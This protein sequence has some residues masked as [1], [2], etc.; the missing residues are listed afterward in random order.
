MFPCDEPGYRLHQSYTTE[1]VA[2]GEEDQNEEVMIADLEKIQID[3]ARG[4]AGCHDAFCES[5]VERGGRD[6]Y[7]SDQDP[8]DHRRLQ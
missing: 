7:L 4:S 3:N 2:H 5:G 8:V 6:E 1:V